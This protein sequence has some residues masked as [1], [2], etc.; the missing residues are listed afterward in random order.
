MK[1][2]Y[3]DCDTEWANRA[4]D[5]VRSKENDAN[6]LQ[7]INAILQS[8]NKAQLQKMAE[9][10]VFLF[11]KGTYPNPQVMQ[12]LSRLSEN[13]RDEKLNRMLRMR[14][15][16]PEHLHQ[17]LGQ[18]ATIHANGSLSGNEKAIVMA[19][20]L[21]H[22][23]DD[24][25][26]QV[27][28]ALASTRA[29]NLQVLSPKTNVEYGPSPIIS[30]NHAILRPADNKLHQ[31]VDSLKQ[32]GGLLDG[33]EENEA[34]A[35]P[36]KSFT[37]NGNNLP[38][39]SET[40]L[41]SFGG[42]PHFVAPKI[43]TPP[44]IRPSPSSFSKA[45]EESQENREKLF[46]IEK[47]NSLF[48]GGNKRI[49]KEEEENTSGKGNQEE[50]F[51]GDDDD[52]GM[53]K[54]L[55]LSGRPH[56]VGG[57]S[58][59][60]DLLPIVPVNPSPTL[61]P[62]VP[63]P[64]LM[65]SR[66]SVWGDAAKLLQES[67]N[68]PNRIGKFINEAV[69]NPE[70]LAQKL[71][72]TL[73]KKNVEIDDHRAWLPS[74]RSDQPPIVPINQATP[75]QP[76]MFGLDR[77]ETNVDRFSSNGPPNRFVLGAL[78]NFGASAAN[79]EAALPG[80]NLPAPNLQQSQFPL[81]S[82]AQQQSSSSQWLVGQMANAGLPNSFG[83]PNSA[84]LAQ[85]GV[86]P[87]QFGG[88]PQNPGL[89]EAQ[90]ISSGL[91]G[92]NPTQNSMIPGLLAQQSQSPVSTAQMIN[93]AYTFPVSGIQR[94][95]KYLQNLPNWTP[96]PLGTEQQQ[97]PGQQPFVKMSGARTF[98][99]YPDHRQGLFPELVPQSLQPRAG[100]GGATDP[101]A[102]KNGQVSKEINQRIDYSSQGIPEN[103]KKYT[104]PGEVTFLE[105]YP[106]RKDFRLPRP[107][108]IGDDLS[109]SDPKGSIPMGRYGKEGWEPMTIRPPI[110]YQTTTVIS[111]PR[112]R[113][114][115]AEGSQLVDLPKKNPVTNPPI[116]RYE[117]G[118][119]EITG[120][121]LRSDVY[122]IRQFGQE[123]YVKIDINPTESVVG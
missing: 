121:H 106:E 58:K 47:K 60:K 23:D 45:Y 29:G 91:L 69:K 123:R 50:R 36:E 120:S 118:P 90:L 41:S 110:E 17:S 85:Q 65:T 109:E 95:Q 5:A 4:I 3:P 96:I 56:S 6:R 51:F 86:L 44:I 38:D 113:W 27:E 87:P 108:T 76:T 26:T 94:G 103:L 92:T 75:N 61:P 88:L 78:P 99:T 13:E 2:F 8:C 101:P 72:E 43:P 52:D 73:Q 102:Y 48:N 66:P 30:K 82:L 104:R 31:L 116:R 83:M 114:F 59:E 11:E 105:T 16:L 7:H 62:N 46:S 111:V 20:I 25:R 49:F 14:A 89:T 12:E 97:F 32:F 112:E 67:T 64:D 34:K 15:Y 22:L 53:E 18:L 74:R 40:L 1:K 119:E 79:F 57:V 100:Y 80:Q 55:F 117:G 21:Q 77:F 9:V 19:R 42:M 71:G 115:P 10:S 39:P 33:D 35:V 28:Q 81:A 68:I 24:D 70:K 122:N 63:D 98:T 107:Q 93:N 54:A 84:L 37:S